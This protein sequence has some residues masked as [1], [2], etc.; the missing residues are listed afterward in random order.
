M[1]PTTSIHQHFEAMDEMMHGNK[2]SGFRYTFYRFLLEKAKVMPTPA[3]MAAK[4]GIPKQCYHTS[5]Q[6]VLRQKGPGHLVY[7]EGYAIPADVGFPMEHAWILDISPGQ[8]QHRVIETTWTK[9]GLEYCGIAF[10][11][12]FLRVSLKKRKYVGLISN[13]EQDYPLLQM[14]DEQLNTAFHPAMEIL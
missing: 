4:R 6:M 13:W 2:P 11:T 8:A 5:G 10:A 7:C 12:L 3:Y 9:P 14:T 1:K